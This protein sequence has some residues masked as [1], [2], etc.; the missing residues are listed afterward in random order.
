MMF[1]NYFCCSVTIIWIGEH[2]EQVMS[3][4][5]NDLVDAKK[6]SKFDTGR[7]VSALAVRTSTKSKLVSQLLSPRDNNLRSFAS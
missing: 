7:C 1:Y 5:Y 4:Q 3:I 2:F 6:R